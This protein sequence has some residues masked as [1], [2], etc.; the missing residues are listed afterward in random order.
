MGGYAGPNL[1]GA[2]VYNAL[3]DF[4]V[5]GTA[6][7]PTV[8][9]GLLEYMAAN[10]KKLHYLKVAAVGGA[11]CPPK[12]LQKFDRSVSV[13]SRLLVDDSCIHLAWLLYLRFASRSLRTLM[14]FQGRLLQYFPVH[15]GFA[16]AVWHALCMLRQTWCL[17]THSVCHGRTPGVGRECW[18]CSVSLCLG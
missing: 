3:E 10:N 1:D 8:F 18:V 17:A 16:T 2:T 12:I 5:G 4:Q 11:A 15:S 14:S 6:G 13:C 7:V 9:L